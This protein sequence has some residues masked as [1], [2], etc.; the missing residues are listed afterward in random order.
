[1]IG[2]F[3]ARTQRTAASNAARIAVTAESPTIMLACC[4]V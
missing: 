2:R 4:V 3:A 1:M